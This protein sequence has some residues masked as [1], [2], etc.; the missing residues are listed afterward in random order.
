MAMLLKLFH[1]SFSYNEDSNSPFF[2]TNLK[3]INWSLRTNLENETDG[4][5]EWDN[6]VIKNGCIYRKNTI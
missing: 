3:T 4:W 1:F 6:R 5:I 2:L